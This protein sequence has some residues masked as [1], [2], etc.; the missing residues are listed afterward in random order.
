[1]NPV[2]L[3][4]FFSVPIRPIAPV[5]CTCV[6]YLLNKAQRRT[7]MTFG[8]MF[9]AEGGACVDTNIPQIS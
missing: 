9:S 6:W 7:M 1:M 3:F 5:M 8:V 2:C 4:M